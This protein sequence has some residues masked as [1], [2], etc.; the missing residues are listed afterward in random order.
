[1]PTAIPDR[2]PTF[3][4]ITQRWHWWST[5]GQPSSFKADL[6]AAEPIEVTWETYDI[7]G[8]RT[9][10]AKLPV[11]PGYARF[12][13]NISRGALWL[14]RPEG[15]WT[16][17]LPKGIK[18]KDTVMAQE[19]CEGMPYGYR[20]PIVC[21]TR[22]STNDWHPNHVDI[23][24]TLEE[25]DEAELG[26]RQTIKVDGRPVLVNFRYLSKIDAQL[27]REYPHLQPFVVDMWS[28]PGPL[29]FALREVDVRGEQQKA[30][31]ITL[32]N[33]VPVVHF[34]GP[35]EWGPLNTDRKI[36]LIGDDVWA[37]RHATPVVID[38]DF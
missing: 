23:A 11:L 13:W 32:P 1:M 2:V 24:T 26:G 9:W 18:R 28:R 15:T 5:P 31:I 29:R 12:L 3:D 35:V 6:A 25:H 17:P 36:A 33:G 38:A 21:S 34:L 20:K 22:A 7:E 10:N 30:L 37:P 27:I 19:P 14:R 4:P 16:T 8:R